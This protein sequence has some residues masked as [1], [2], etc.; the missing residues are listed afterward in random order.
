MLPEQKVAMLSQILALSLSYLLLPGCVS[1]CHHLYFR[2]FNS[3]EIL[4]IQRALNNQKV[5]LEGII[6]TST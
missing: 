3:D 1:T 6:S 2:V 5:G 4:S